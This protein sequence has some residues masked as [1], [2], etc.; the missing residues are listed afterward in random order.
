MV[1]SPNL[2]LPYIMP[3]QAQ[4][5]VTHNE[6]LRA[7]DAIVQLA[8]A[9]KDLDTPPG[10]PDT[11]ARYIVG[12][13]PSGA[14]T[15]H[16]NDIAAW[17][18]EAWAFYTPGPG[19][20]AWVHDESQLYLFSGGGWS[21]APGGGGAGIVP[22][23]AWNGSETY[24]V[25]DLVEHEGHPYVSNID[26]NIGNEP[27]ESPASSAAW[28]YFSMVVGTG[29]GGGGG[30]GEAETLG[31]NAT[32]DTTNRL[33]VSSPAS[34]FS[35]EGDDHRL[36][37]NKAATAATGS[38]LFQ[39]DFSGRAEFGLAGDDDFRVKVSADGSEWSDAI[40]VDSASGKVA[41]PHTNV[42]TNFA[43]SLLP[44][45]GRFAGNDATATNVSAYSF[46]SYLT[47]YNSSTH[48]SAGKFITN[49]NDYG[50]SAGALP[51]DIKD[52]IDL[53]RSPAHRRYNVEFFVSEITMGSGTAST[54]ITVEA[55]NYY[56]SLFL[57]FGPR[58][59]AMTFHV[60]LRALD[61]RI[62]YR[63]YPG[64]TIIKDGV[65]STENVTIDPADG[66]VSITVEDEQDP[67]ESV[68]YNPLPLNIYARSGEKYL[69][70]C[71][72]LMGG[73]TQVD[74]NIGIIAGVNRWLP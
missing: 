32:A 73:I 30:D 26:A 18:D 12:A 37:I 24:A 10:S 27:D 17:Q 71:P 4:K 8:V 54:P 62:V 34:L 46:P 56:Y 1:S 63:A 38:V 70:A 9:D 11:G 13:S 61:D 67:Y 45:S 21:A 49:N 55:V 31:V 43:V 2:N 41:L 48:A 5:H 68:G 74:D 64:Q 25:G 3:S 58:V 50:G 23:G 20:L 40:T 35:H 59:P 36:K 57:T 19:W 53:I 47:V 66:W 6:A 72:A 14:W 69:L 65:R 16:A 28:T 15:G 29:G 44:D 39:T 33:A 51:A 7:L 42:L 60:Y 22:K 52:L